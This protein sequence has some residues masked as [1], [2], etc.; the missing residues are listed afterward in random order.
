MTRAILAASGLLLTVLP[1]R[2]RADLPGESYKNH[3]IFSVGVGFDTLGPT[4]YDAYTNAFNASNGGKPGG[5]NPSVAIHA[6]LALTYY[7]PYYILVRTGLEP[8]Y[9]FPSEQIG[10]TSVTNYGGTI[11]IPLFL[12]GHYALLDERLIVELGLGPALMAFTSAGLNGNDGSLAY[13][14]LYADPSF[15]FDSELKGQFFVSHGFSVG[16]ELGYRVLS[17]NVLHQS[18]QHGNYQPPFPPY[19]TPSGKPIHLDLSGFRTVLELGFGI[20]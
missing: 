2:A 9:F 19:D 17:S 5:A 14:Q 10:S 8:D 13:Q 16:L 6:S 4:D 20:L 1:A 7:G 15:G 18:G 12:G 11:E 3:L